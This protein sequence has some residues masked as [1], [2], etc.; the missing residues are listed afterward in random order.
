MVGMT[1]QCA[2]LIFD[3]SIHY[4]D[5]LAPFCAQMKWPLIVCDT[6]VA[7][8]CLRF[9]PMTDVIHTNFSKLRLPPC[10]VSCDNRPLL[11]SALGPFSSWGGRFIWLP[12]GQSD[13]GWKAPYFEALGSEDLLLVYGERMRQV[14]RSKNIQVPQVSVGNFRWQFYQTHYTFYNQLMEKQFGKHRFVLYAPTWDDSEQNGSFWQVFES[15]IKSVPPHV[16]LCIKVHPN[17]Q[18]MFPAKL[19]RC[20]GRAQELKHISFI[21]DFP[22]IYPLL[23]RA[24]AYIG[25]M[26]SIGYDYLRFG[27]PLLFLMN[28]KIDPAQDSRGYLMQWGQQIH[29]D[30]ISTA[31]SLNLK[32]CKDRSL[33]HLAFD[34]S[35]VENTR[36][37]INQWIL[38]W[39]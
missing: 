38:A 9:Y 10:I 24:D 21:D 11:A 35:N 39:E 23:D 27:R 4:I 5:H 36:R 7:E 17:M 6:S 26:S 30:E 25:D 34:Q 37:A 32:I 18:K 16:H 12:H 33:T 22:P 15:L 8:A 1:T 13:K 2:G 31:F 20:R 3:D 19:E 14:L 29:Y 28:Q